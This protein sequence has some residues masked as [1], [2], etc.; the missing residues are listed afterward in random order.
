MDFYF[1]VLIPFEIK[2]KEDNNGKSTYIFTKDSKLLPVQQGADLV[3][4]SYD[5]QIPP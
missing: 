4:I 1:W 3:K 5:T 2:N